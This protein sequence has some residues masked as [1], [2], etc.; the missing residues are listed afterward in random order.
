[1][2]NPY[3]FEFSS[4]TGGVDGA[5]DSLNTTSV[6]DASHARVDT[7]SIVYTYVFNSGSSDVGDAVVNKLDYALRNTTL[8]KTVQEGNPAIKF[9]EIFQFVN[10]DL[11]NA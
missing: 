9:D 7:G 4:L 3:V 11:E 2:A 6:P 5:L 10:S 1:M 8:R